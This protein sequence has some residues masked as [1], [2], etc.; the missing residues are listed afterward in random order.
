MIMPKAQ[1][2]ELFLL[3]AQRWTFEAAPCP[4]VLSPQQ[5]ESSSDVEDIGELKEQFIASIR[6]N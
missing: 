5:V 6:E 4:G 2:Y 3:W 1:I